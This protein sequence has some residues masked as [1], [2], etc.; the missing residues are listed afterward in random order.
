VLRIPNIIGGRVNLNDLKFGPTEYFERDEDLIRVGDLLVVRTNGSR[1]L[2]GR[3]AV[4]RDEQT[5]KLSFASYLIRLRLV[6][7]AAL[8]LWVSL[9]WDTFHVRRWIETRAATSAGQYNISLGVLETLILPVPPAAEQDAIVEAAEGQLSIIDHLEANFESK[10][11]SAHGLRQTI[12]RHA[13]T[14]KLV[15]QDPNDE[16]ASEL[17]KRISTEREQRARDA[18]AAKRSD[19]RQPRRVLMGQISGKAG[20]TVT[21]E[22]VNGRIADR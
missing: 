18:A 11:K 2:I 22:T 6:P 9:L 5:T 16:P 19:G 21:K 14:G 7:N 4:V 13:F 20:R 1:N 8:L 12:L 15:P 17:L 3:G 10:L